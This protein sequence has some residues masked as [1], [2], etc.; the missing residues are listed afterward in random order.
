[1]KAMAMT[2]ANSIVAGS[3]VQLTPTAVCSRRTSSNAWAAVTTEALAIEEIGAVDKVILNAVADTTVYDA[4]ESVVV[5]KWNGDGLDRILPLA[6]NVGA[7]AGVE[8]EIDG[9]LVPELDE[10]RRQGSH[11]V[12]ET[13]RFCE[14]NTLRGGKDNMH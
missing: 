5:L 14:G 3:S 1:M 12:G 2:S 8:R 10:F 6:L 9:N 13:A 7:D 4:D 11:H